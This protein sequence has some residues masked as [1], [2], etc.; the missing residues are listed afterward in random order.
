[1]TDTLLNPV[2]GIGARRPPGAGRIFFVSASGDNGNNGINPGTPFATITYALTQCV[3]E[4]GDY[5]FILTTPTEPAYPVSIAL[6]KM[7]IIGISNPG[8]G[9][10][11]RILAGA[12]Q[13]FNITTDGDHLEVAGIGFGADNEDAMWGIQVYN[14]WIHHCAFGGSPNFS[15][16]PLRTGITGDQWPALVLED[17]LFGTSGEPWGTLAG[18]GVHLSGL[19]NCMIRRNLFMNCLLGAIRSSGGNMEIGAILDN[20]IYA[21]IAQVMAQGWGINISGVGATYGSMI[22]GNQA[23][24]T[25]DS[26]VDSNPYQDL[27]TGVLATSGGWGRNYVNDTPTDPAVV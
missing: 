22:D 1:M 15:G 26:T 3:A 20:R 8:F 10:D 16:N 17:C 21:G 4:R 23:T 19:V 13:C 24:Q 5:I 2:V 18:Y 14:A 7:H 9:P 25:G 12:N 11:I 6:A 27:T